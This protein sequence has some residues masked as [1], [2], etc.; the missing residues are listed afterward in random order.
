MLRAYTCGENVLT[1]RVYRLK[2]LLYD[3]VVSAAKPEQYA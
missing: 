2:M 3:D 1:G